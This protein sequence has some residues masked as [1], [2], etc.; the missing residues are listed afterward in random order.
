MYELIKNTAKR[1]IPKSF[2]KR[3]EGFFRS[4]VALKYRGDK[5]ECN[6]CGFHLNQFVQLSNIN[7][8]LCPNC[9]SLPRTRRLTKILFSEIN[10]EN[11]N[12]LHFSPP[13]AL[14]KKIKKINPEGYVTTDYMDEFEADKKL[15]ITN[16]GEP[17]HS[18][19]LIICYHVLEHIEEDR[20][21]MAEL[22]RILKP[23]GLVLIQ[24][25]FKSGQIY[26]N[27]DIKTPEDRLKHFGQ[28]DHV[29]IYSVEG[30]VERLEQ[31]G[32][33]L[34]VRQFEEEEVYFGLK[35]GEVI[36]FANKR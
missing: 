34:G 19:D 29:R 21:A 36:L 20:K 14:K 26:E 12:I 13:N 9:G 31:N 8:K 25:P 30:L 18:Y 17:N 1:I 2:L 10:V 27:K 23:N 7:E 11:K 22:F 24:T 35:K 3:N 5:F 33:H 32:F 16:I 4:L 15:D 28:D 6:V